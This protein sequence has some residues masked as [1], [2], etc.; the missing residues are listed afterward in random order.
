[1][2]KLSGDVLHRIAP[3]EGE[4]APGDLVPYKVELH[5]GRSLTLTAAGVPVT[6]DVIKDVLSKVEIPSG[7]RFGV[8]T[9][10][11]VHP[12][13]KDQD[14]IVGLL[15]GKVANPNIPFISNEIEFW[16]GGVAG[17]HTPEPGTFA[18]I[19][20]G[21]V[22]LGLRR[23][24][25][26]KTRRHQAMKRLGSA[27][28]SANACRRVVATAALLLCGLAVFPQRA[29][30]VALVLELTIDE[31]GKGRAVLSGNVI[32][33][34]FPSGEAVN[35]VTGTNW[36]VKTTLLRRSV[37]AEPFTY[38]LTAAARHL[39]KPHPGEASQGLLLGGFDVLASHVD[40]LNGEHVGFLT[41]NGQL[42]ARFDL[43]HT[44]EPSSLILLGSGFLGL[45]G[46]RRRRA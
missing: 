38:R 5:G 39:V 44:P 33:T 14:L 26:R 27:R 6:S 3:H 32:K 31:I 10:E 35:E 8:D 15:E 37:E 45:A 30:A 42:S 20:L 21:L 22:G 36:F 13:G 25:S 24:A 23:R 16:A 11:K 1:M 4:L 41:F 40:D 12:E 34:E 19:G 29:H 28:V 46:L 18:L 17:T 43:A 9:N 2:L 7:G